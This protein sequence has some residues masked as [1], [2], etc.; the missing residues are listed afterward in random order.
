MILPSDRFNNDPWAK[1]H[2]REWKVI[3]SYVDEAYKRRQSPTTLDEVNWSVAIRVL[4]E[5]ETTGR[6]AYM[7][8]F[9]P[10]MRRRHH[11]LIE[12]YEMHKEALYGA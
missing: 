6:D 10:Y 4:M 5:Y 8:G 3:A 1:S 7:K 11:K 9:A 2:P 12:D